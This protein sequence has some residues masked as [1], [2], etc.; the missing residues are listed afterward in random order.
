[1]IP[2]EYAGTMTCD[3]GRSYDAKELREVKQQKCLGHVQRSLS[4]V[5]ESKNTLNPTVLR[6]IRELMA[7]SG[8]KRV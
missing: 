7:M 4:D 1:M 3:R 5:L 6:C 8:T 2:S